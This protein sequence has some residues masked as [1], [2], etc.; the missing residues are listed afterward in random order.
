MKTTIIVLDKTFELKSK[1]S[2]S[3]VNFPNSESDTIHNEFT[4]SVT[5]KDKVT[6]RFKYYDSQANYE[7]G[8]NDL[9]EEDLKCCFRCFIEDGL[10]GS[11]TFE[12]FC[13]NFG[14]STDS[15]RA[16]RIYKLCQKSL[17][18]LFDLGITESELTD[19][20]NKL[21]EMGIE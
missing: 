8:K 9:T 10:S 14:Y 1:L 15:I 16:N 13:S 3:G 5:N 20:L 6:R 2:R 19:I 11:E 21:S 12:D 18:K 17:E 7:A 4:V